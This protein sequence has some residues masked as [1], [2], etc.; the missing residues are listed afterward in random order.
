MSK[1]IPYWQQRRALKLEG[2]KPAKVER[3]EKLEKAKFFSD[4]LKVAPN[5]CQECNKPLVPTAAINPSAI[6]A[7]ILA[8]SKKQGVPSMATNPLNRVFLCGDCHTDM[9]NHGCE[10]IQQMKIYPL[11]KQRVL[12]MWPG[13]PQSERRRVPECLR[14]HND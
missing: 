12:L 2:A 8:K 1:N 9:D 11:L 3:A 6:V 7:H 10:Y 4:A 13:I 5:R 14:P